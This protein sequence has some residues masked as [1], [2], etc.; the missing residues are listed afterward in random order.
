M[1]R[2]TDMVKFAM[3]P[4]GFVVF[5]RTFLPYQ[6]YRFLWVNLRMLTMIWKSHARVKE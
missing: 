3:K 6:I 5:L 1:N 2:P 4:S